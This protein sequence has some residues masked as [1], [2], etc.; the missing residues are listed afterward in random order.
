MVPSACH[1]LFQWLE[2]NPTAIDTGLPMLDQTL[3][4][5]LQTSMFFGGLIGL[6]LDN[7]IPGKA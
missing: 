6:I 4:V 3:V 7:T 5:L 1:P 2:A